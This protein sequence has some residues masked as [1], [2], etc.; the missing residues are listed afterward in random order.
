MVTSESP[1][2]PLSPSDASE[3]GEPASEDGSA[4]A[5]PR[6][7][8]G[9]ISAQLAHALRKLGGP[10]SIRESLEEMIEES[11]DHSQELSSQ[12][13][14]M[15]G[16]LLN[17][18]KLRVEDVMVPRADIIAVEEN[19]S[20]Q[21][22]LELFREAQHSRLPIYHETLD[23]PRGMVHVKDVLALLEKDSESGMRW[24]QTPLSKIRRDVIYVPAAMSVLDLL[25]KMQASHIHLALVVDEYGGTDG[26]VSIENLVEEI[27]G[28]IDDEHDVDDEPQILAK[29][30]GSFDADARA[31]LDDFK[32]KTGIDLSDGQTEDDID[33]LGGLVFA[34]LGRVPVRGEIV[35]VEQGFEFEVLEAD[36]RRVKRLRI[37]P[38]PAERTNASD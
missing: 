14:L 2:R 19:T 36:A 10:S 22:L 4:R 7:L 37:R 27:V 38:A 16:N 30:D 17:F 31:A 11:E 12:E 3:S 24:Q 35:V 26:L 8:L 18:G 1:P 13:R 25:L 9:E 6:S 5:S 32:E 29:S 23:D 15:L 21:D 34:E 20:L 28:D 33:T